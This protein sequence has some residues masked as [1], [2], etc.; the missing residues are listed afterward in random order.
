[1]L[2]IEGAGRLVQQQHRGG[3]GEG[4]GQVHELALPSGELVDRVVGERADAG[5]VEGVLDDAAVLRGLP[6]LRVL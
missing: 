2:Q 3:L 6:A 5:D 1:M 4:A